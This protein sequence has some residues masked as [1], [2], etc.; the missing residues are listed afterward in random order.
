MEGTIKKGIIS[1]NGGISL[2]NNDQLSGYLY[3]PTA[4]ASIGN[5]ANVTGSIIAKSVTIGN[6]CLITYGGN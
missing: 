4:G 2:G 6:S 1:T 3:V 5:S